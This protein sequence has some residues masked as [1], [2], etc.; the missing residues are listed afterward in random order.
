LDFLATCWRYNINCWDRKFQPVYSFASIV[1]YY[2][3]FRWKHGKS[4]KQPAWRIAG[5]HPGLYV[6]KYK[7]CDPRACSPPRPPETVG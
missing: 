1:S 6:S 7:E 2:L 5:L 3:Y 4:F